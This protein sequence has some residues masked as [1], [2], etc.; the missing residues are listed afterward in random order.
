MLCCTYMHMS[1]TMV[2]RAVLA[3]HAFALIIV[4]ACGAAIARNCVGGLPHVPWGPRLGLP[5]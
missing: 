3:K 4:H 5:S 2:K 1:F